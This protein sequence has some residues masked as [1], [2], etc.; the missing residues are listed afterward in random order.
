MGSELKKV[1]SCVVMLVEFSGLFGRFVNLDKEIRDL[2]DY[3]WIKK[4]GAAGLPDD[5]KY[6]YRYFTP[7][8]LMRMQPNVFAL[9][10]ASGSIGYGVF[11]YPIWHK[12]EHEDILKITGIEIKNCSEAL[13]TTRT[14]TLGAFDHTQIIKVY[15]ETKSMNET[16]KKTDRS[17][18][19]VY[20]HIQQHN[21][22]V[23]DFHECKKCHNANVPF[24]KIDILI[25]KA[26]RPK[27]QKAYV[28]LNAR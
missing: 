23:R 7:F 3:T 17:F 21:D 6:V 27:K 20:N 26:G 14:H 8:S 24:S 11:D 19:T 2:A 9:S 13:P 18:K 25:P 16:A 15:F 5:L 12:T 28:E 10:T 4:L 22:D 1:D